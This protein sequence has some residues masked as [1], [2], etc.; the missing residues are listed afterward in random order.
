MKNVNNVQIAKF[1]PQGLAKHFFIKISPISACK[2]ENI[3]QN[4][5]TENN[6]FKT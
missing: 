6:S 4:Q 3:Y 1:E 5:A 2:V